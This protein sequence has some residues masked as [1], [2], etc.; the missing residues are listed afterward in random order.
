MFIGAHVIFYT[1]DAEADRTFL[2]DVLGFAHVD[3][4]DGWLVFRLPPAEAAVHP[5]TLEPRQEVYLMCEDLGRTLT[6]LEDR[7]AEISRAVTEQPWGLLAA[8]RLPSGTELPLYEPRH[9]TAL[10][11]SP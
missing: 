3:A 8:V 6:A 5:T 1:R 9:P 7:G 11:L 10:G 2:K 4:G